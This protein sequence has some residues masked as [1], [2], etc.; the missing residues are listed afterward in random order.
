MAAIIFRVATVTLE[1]K[2]VTYKLVKN[3][4]DNGCREGGKLSLSQRGR[5]KIR[6]RKTE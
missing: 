4:P 5:E 3:K 6:N 1:I 2:N